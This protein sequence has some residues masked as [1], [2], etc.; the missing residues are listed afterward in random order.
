MFWFSS[1]VA[2]MTRLLA[3][4][5]RWAAIISLSSAV[6]S[7]FEPSSSP[8]AIVPTPGVPGAPVVAVPEAELAAQRVPLS[9][10]RPATFGKFASWIEPSWVTA[11][12]ASV[13]LIAPAALT[14]NFVAVIGTL[15]FPAA[16]EPFW[17]TRKRPSGVTRSPFASRVKLPARV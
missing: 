3:W 5:E 7:T 16:P 17:P 10:V 4:N 9:R 12:V 1:S 6:R 15:T 2:E 11:P 8:W 13:R 14:V